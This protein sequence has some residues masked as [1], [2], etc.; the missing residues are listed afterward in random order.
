MYRVIVC[1]DN[2]EFLKVII[3][4]L[5]KYADLYDAEVLGFDN[6]KDL[7]KYCQS[8]QFDIVYMD[9][10]IGKENGMCLAMMLKSINPNLLII[11]ISA[12]N[13]YYVDMVQAEPFH[14]ILKD[15][16]DAYKLEK[17]VADTLEAAMNRI[18]P[19]DIW[20]YTFR[21]EQYRIELS[22]I[23]YFRSVARTIH[24]VGNIGGMPSYF[25]GKLDELEKEVA[26]IDKKFVRISK[27]IIVN[28]KY[29]SRYGNNRVKILG[30]VFSVSSK[31]RSILNQP[32]WKM[33]F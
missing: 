15:Y 9:I 27:S 26:G 23:A 20:T 29:A 33:T 16:S 24:I 3:S 30:E 12:Y 22:K 19:K 25:Y 28:K 14:F 11:Y 31:Y 7:L 32:D 1:D 6:G 17:Q 5:K 4:F 18:D 2:V 8:N 21:R 10:E 13:T